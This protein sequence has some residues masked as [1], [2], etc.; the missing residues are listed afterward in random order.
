MKNFRLITFT[1]FMFFLFGSN[2]IYAQAPIELSNKNATVEAKAL[3]NYLLA[4]R[5]KKILS[6]Q[7]FQ[8]SPV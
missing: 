7:W 3:Y 2:W 5:G 8:I 6:G 1:V 4:I